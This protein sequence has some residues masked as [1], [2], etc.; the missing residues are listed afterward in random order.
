MSMLASLVR[1]Y[2]RLPDAPPFGYSTEKIGFCVLLNADGSVAS[3]EDLRGDDRKRSPRMLLV[4]QAVKRTAGIAPNFLWDKS[5]YVL[6]VTAGEGKR[7]AEEHAAFRARHAE[8][9]A[10]ADDPGLRAFLRF[11]DCWSPDALA[12]PLWPDE[13]RDQNIVFALAEEYRDRFLHDRPAARE[14]WR[15]LGAEGASD[16]QICLVT[17]EPGSVARLHPSIKGVWGAQSSGASL[18]SFNLDAFTSYGHDQ[19]DNAPVSEAAAFAYGTVLNRYLDKDSGHRIQIGDASTVFWADC[20]DMKLATEAEVFFA[21]LLDPASEERLVAED[22]RLETA[23]IHSRLDSIRNGQRLSQVAPELAEGVRFHV[24]GLAP[25]AARLSVRFYWQ[26]DFGRLTANFQRYLED[27]AID[28]PPRDGWPPLWRYLLELAS[29]GKRENVP[30][31]IAG[32]WLR[33]ILTG[34]AYPLTL[35]S[36]V[37]MR[38]RADGEIN[39]LRCAMLK[40]VLIRNF[41][42]KEAPVA[43]DPTSR[44]TGYVLGRLFAV[45]ENIQRAALGKS[46]N[47]TIRDKFYGSASATPARVFGSLAGNAFNHLARIRKDKPAFAHYLQAELQEIANLLDVSKEPFPASL[48]QEAQAKFA[49]GYYHQASFR[50]HD[51]KTPEVSQ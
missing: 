22:E 51:D 19:G 25:N 16:P 13:M 9:L 46:V 14:L 39:A 42:Y 29:Q 3:V 7:T 4:P 34:T 49:L 38:M 18:V 33:A 32:E 1:A 41:H 50:K 10:E 37:L 5:A 36:T 44:D 28:P 31:L 40:S 2:D 45:Y 24:L 26:D 47:A 15:R 27:T 20:S 43:L 6:G 11:L 17:G 21:A 23:R 8:W 35:L 12:P 48:S 30:P